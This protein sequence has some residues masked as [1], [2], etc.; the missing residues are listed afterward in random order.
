[1]P[2]SYLLSLIT[3]SPL[4]AIVILAFVPK[5]QGGIL[6][7]I[8]ILGT[9]LPLVLSFLLFANF[10]YGDPHMQFV[11][12]VNWISIPVGNP[13]MGEVFSF[14]INY[15]MG[16]DGVSM[17]LIV[18]TAIIGTLAAVAS[19]QIKK[20]L[21]EYFILFHLLLIGMFGVFAAQN[22][23]LFFIFFELTLVP[24]YF[25]IGI[26]GYSDRERAANTFL[27]Y[28]GVGSAIMLIAFLIIY[29]TIPGVNGNP[30]M[31]FGELAA[32]LSTP[33]N[34][35]LQHVSPSL[36]F[37]L[38]LALFIAFGIKLPVFPFHTWM[39]KVHVQAPPSIVMIH[40]GILLKMGAYG[41]LRIGIGFFPEQAYQFATWMAVL[42]LIN[43]LYGA[44]LAF[45]QKDLKMVLAYSS[46]SH[47][48]I[49][50]LGFAAMNSIGFQGAIFQV[51]SHGFISALMFF[52]IGV[53]WERTETSMI[54]ELGGLAKSMP[55]I[56]GVLLA[57]AMASL[58]LPGMSG[59]IS[60]FLAFLGLFGVKPVMAAVGTLGIIL[61]A[62]YLL[63]AVLRTTFG[64]MP[65]R[66]QG[67]ADAQPIEVIPMVVLLGFIIL[68]G[69]YPAVL[70]EPLQE[71][72][73]NIVPI[74][75]GMGG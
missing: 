15:E 17:P 3:L 62:V 59:F 50:L 63:R 10:N 56:S 65:D 19:W 12:K 43:V 22:L 57:A 42:G 75:P 52:L 9:L 64:P 71:T 35:M 6:K 8:G 39:L 36:L 60:E 67:A 25:L 16:V 58:G 72:L 44:V 13:Q 46:I 24:M 41:L 51:I 73:K 37:G 74:V 45:V 61:T 47:M 28:N 53:I 54:S 7:Q 21:K 2:N 31:N 49:V 26:W 29:L 33:N 27:L 1:M 55:F 66:Y 11:E 70:S 68:I 40:S 4:V 23:L 20:R 14:T 5:N 30:T 32:A 48:G 38:F 69:I 34:P 18:L